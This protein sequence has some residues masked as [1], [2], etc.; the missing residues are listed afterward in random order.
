MLTAYEQYTFE[1]LNEYFSKL[2]NTTWLIGRNFTSVFDVNK[3]FLPTDNLMSDRWVDIIAKNGN[4][5]PYPDEVYVF[6]RL[7]W[8]PFKELTDFIDEE[9]FKSQWIDII[10]KSLNAID[11]FDISPY[12]YRLTTRHPNEQAHQ[13]WAEYL[14]KKLI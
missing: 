6:S 13:W 7:G 9:K 11:W 12:N 10:D 2:H 3:K 1:L 14:Y 4:L 5:S 8:K